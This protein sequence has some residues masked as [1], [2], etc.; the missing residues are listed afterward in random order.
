M[1]ENAGVTHLRHL[2]LR[3]DRRDLGLALLALGV[4]VASLARFSHGEPNLTGYSIDLDVYRLGARAWLS[5]RD[6]YGGLPPTQNGL[7]L[8]FTYPPIAAVVLAPLTL[9]PAPVAAI[10]V[11]AVSLGLLAATTALMLERSGVLPRTAAIRLAV[12]LM[13]AAV[14]F[15][16]IRSTL[17]YGQVNVA[18]MAM[19]AFDCLSPRVHWPRGALVGLAAAIKLTPAVFVLYFLIHRQWRAAAN[20]AGSFLAVG[21]L[22]AL[23][24]PRDSVRYWTAAVFDTGRVGS[25]T[26]AAD[27]SLN[28][29]LARAHLSGFALH[30][31]WLGAAA[32]V[33]CLAS[34][35]VARAARARRP[36]H[37]LALTACA[38]LLVSPISWSHHW[39]WAAPVLLTAAVA[40]H[41]GANRRTRALVY[42]SVV[43]F[44][45]GPQRWLPGGGG[46]EPHWSWWQ[47]IIGSAYVWAALAALLAAV[48]TN[49]DRRRG[50]A[51]RPVPGSRTPAWSGSD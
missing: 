17:G 37:A 19:V 24:A 36:V 12:A 13:P 42:S 10:L 5:G 14:L 26:L 48:F 9:V 33:G 32:A 46:G 39:V 34:A 20:A 7:H 41:R 47:Q 1:L 30:L 4:L 3:A 2:S 18:L 16:P 8:G 15:E 28:G 38:A 31:A 27:Q 43:L 21:A 50:P 40:A 25:V 29:V 35:G 22:G 51:G 23:L 49:A 45:V 44:V 6:L 11:T